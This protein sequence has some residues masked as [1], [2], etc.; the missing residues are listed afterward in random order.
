MVWCAD[1]SSPCRGRSCCPHFVC[2][3]FVVTFCSLFLE[4]GNTHNRG[5]SRAYFAH[6]SL[7]LCIAWPYAGKPLLYTL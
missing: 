7:K 4:A 3:H 5:N 6:Y 1:G 2:V